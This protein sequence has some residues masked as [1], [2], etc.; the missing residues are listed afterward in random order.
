ML[1]KKL[2]KNKINKNEKIKNHKMIKNNSMIT[3]NIINQYVRRT[4]KLVLVF[5]CF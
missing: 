1:C 4:I 2:Y 5:S 3:H